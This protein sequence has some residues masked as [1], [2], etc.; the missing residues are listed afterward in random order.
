MS[1]LVKLEYFKYIYFA[2]RQ[3]EMAVT[4]VTELVEAVKRPRAL[5]ESRSRPFP[6]KS[7][8]VGEDGRSATTMVRRKSETE[9]V[10][11]KRNSHGSA[12]IS[13]QRISEVPEKKPRKSIR[14]SFMG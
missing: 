1:R 4:S 13:M 12:R 14:L 10:P 9:A 8:G 5:S 7:E 2:A 3:K 11:P 6:R